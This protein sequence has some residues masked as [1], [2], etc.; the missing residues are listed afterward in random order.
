MRSRDKFPIL[1][2]VLYLWYNF[3][4]DGTLSRVN[5]RSYKHYYMHYAYDILHYLGVIPARPACATPA[6]T[7]T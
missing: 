1:F 4:R 6:A 3:V 7:Y 5:M 2:R